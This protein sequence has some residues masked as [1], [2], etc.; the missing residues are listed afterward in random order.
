[1]YKNLHVELQNKYLQFLFFL[2]LSFVCLKFCVVAKMKNRLCFAFGT[3]AL[4]GVTVSQ[5]TFNTVRDLTKPDQ[6]SVYLLLCLDGFFVIN[7]FRVDI[8]GA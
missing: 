6:V 5:Y 2:S 4:F 3:K 8:P 1:M 7:I